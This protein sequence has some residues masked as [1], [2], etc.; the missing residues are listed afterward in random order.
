[1]DGYLFTED[2]GI[3]SV[4][5]RDDLA[6]ML[7]VVHIRADRP[8]L[9][10]L[11]VKARHY[12][13]PLSKTV[14][15][16]MLKG[17]RFPR[18]AVMLSFLRAC[19]VAEEAMEP[20][21]RSW[22]RIAASE[23]GARSRLLPAG[24]DGQ[25]RSA[26][27]AVRGTADVLADE[28]AELGIRVS[29]T[30]SDIF[31]PLV[32]EAAEPPHMHSGQESAKGS[33]GPQV[34]RRELGALLRQLRANAGLTIEQV[35]ERLL[36]SPSKVSR[37]ETGFRAGTMRDIRDLCDL[38]AVTDRAQ[39]DHLME[40][41]RQSKRQGWWQSYD[42]PLS[43][44]VHLGA[45]LGLEEDATSIS[46]FQPTIIPGLLQT[47]D[48][49]REI[50]TV[51]ELSPQV[52]DQNVAVRLRRQ[53]LLTRDSPPEL[54]V[55]IDEAALRRRVGGPATMK[56]QLD[57]LVARSRLPN[58]AIQVI[59]SDRGAY[60]GMGDSFN[61]LSFPGQITDIVWVEGLF[62]MIYLE[63]PQDVERYKDVFS[64]ARSVAMEGQESTELITRISREMSDAY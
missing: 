21:L 26:S 31:T 22:E 29:T 39:R 7:R 32:E 53:D 40:L 13:T 43:F 17:T 54:R 9:R 24:H 63:R 25:P 4:Q 47:Q 36:C 11:E 60:K 33:P 30:P 23:Q 2:I 57:Q 61:I 51:H 50:M 59:P 52:I 6:T 38:Y 64:N 58:V 10:A 15:S 16:E 37:M 27:Q 41:V 62:G 12:Q 44:S 34:S 35:A 18:K 46:E 45:Y 19:G 14:V 5:T 8:S 28:S 3:S 42:L 1:M 49:A 20:W 55:V 48:Y 56:A